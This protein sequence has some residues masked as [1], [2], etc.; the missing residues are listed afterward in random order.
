MSNS[1]DDSKFL[2]ENFQ[3]SLKSD[4]TKIS[5]D[6]LNISIEQVIHNNQNGSTVVLKLPANDYFTFNINS[7]KYLVDKDFKGIYISFCRPY[8]NLKGLLKENEIDT[9]KIIIMDFATSYSNKK[10]YDYLEDIE[11]SQHLNVDVL[12]DSI[13]DSLNQLDCKNKFIFIDSIT[14]FALYKNPSEIIRFSDFLSNFSKAKNDENLI[15]IFNVAEILSKK[16]YVKDICI[17]ADIV[18]DLIN[19]EERKMNLAK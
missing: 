7:I 3:N 5:E 19:S 12:F 15:V 13:K 10:D 11:I 9:N 16:E 1:I 14:T 8:N 2:D 18:I 4:N 6:I 17:H